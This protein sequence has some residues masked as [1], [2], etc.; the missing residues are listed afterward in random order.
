[1]KNQ[2]NFELLAKAVQAIKDNPNHWNQDHWHCG[3]SHCLAGFIHLIETFKEKPLSE[4]LRQMLHDLYPDTDLKEPIGGSI[5][6]KCTEEFARERLSIT[7]DQ[8]KWLFSY[9]RTIRDFEIC[10]E[11]KF[12]PSFSLDPSEG[13][14]ANYR[15]YQMA[16]VG[17]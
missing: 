12:V 5:K 10:L 3:T 15:P 11:V 4:T 14:T 7:N 17:A 2:I 16:F 6:G 9:L 13:L 1:M 8:A